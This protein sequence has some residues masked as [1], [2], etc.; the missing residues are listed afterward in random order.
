MIDLRI[1]A[2]SPGVHTF[3]L[4]P[5]PDD[6]D[7]GDQAFRD[8]T[9]DVRLD[10]SD[11]QA[12]VTLD[13][14]AI[15]ALVCDR[16]MVD[17]EEHVE[18]THEVVFSS[19][20]AHAIDAGSE[21]TDDLLPLDAGQTSLDLTTPVRDTLMLSLPQ[22]RIAPGAEDAEI[23]TTFGALKD[24]DGDVVDARWQALLDRKNEN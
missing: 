11:H 5:S 10:L 4:H 20:A 24:D 13:T 2:L 12:H 18:G 9:V 3:T 22:R 19:A 15:A 21:P 8:I 16:T 1:S 17:F 14:S 6:L 23:P 7:L